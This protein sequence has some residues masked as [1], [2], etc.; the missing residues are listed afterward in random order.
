MTGDIGGKHGRTL[1]YDI[2]WATDNGMVRKHN[3]DS[4]LTLELRLLDGF[5]GISADLYAVA[6]GVGGHEGGEVASSLALRVLTSKVLEFLLLPGLKGEIENVNQGFLSKVLVEG[7][8]IANSEVYSQGQGKNSDMATTLAAVLVIDSTA[9]IA[10]VG[11]SRVYSLDGDKLTQVTTDHSLVASL[12]SAG[13]ITQ[14]EIYTHPQRNIITRCLGTEADVEVDLFTEE[15][16]SGISLILCS[17]GLWEMVRDN[18]I[19]DIV[20]KAENPQKAYEQLIKTANKN[21]GMD[22]ISVVIFRVSS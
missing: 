20:L 10:N 18:T 15:V 19:K 1:K 8:K 9:Y 7:I 21:G 16:K 2:G 3:E 13:E 4:L 14:E 22:N 17:D 5:E 12:V 6:D 11:D